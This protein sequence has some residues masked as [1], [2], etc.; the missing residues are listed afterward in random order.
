MKYSDNLIKLFTEIISKS[1][2]KCS[3]LNRKLSES[4][5][6][7]AY[8]R[9]I[10]NSIHYTRFNTIINGHKINGKYLNEKVNKWSK[11]CIFDKMYHNTK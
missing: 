5:Y 10:D 1:D 4:D 2:I 3:K 9:F 7:E 6:F 8:L 11:Y